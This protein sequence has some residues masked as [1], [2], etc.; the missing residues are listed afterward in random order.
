MIKES[1]EYYLSQPAI[2][3]GMHGMLEEVDEETDE[4]QIGLSFS[5]FDLPVKLPIGMYIDW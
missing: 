4:V 1:P 5:F 3:F 2:Y